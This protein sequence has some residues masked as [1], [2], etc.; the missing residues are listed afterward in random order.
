MFLQKYK[1]LKA[2]LNGNGYIQLNEL[3]EALK[4][5][6][7]DIPGYQARALEEEFKKSDKNHDGKLNLE[8]FEKL[9]A[10][11]KNEKEERTF[12][13]SVKPPSGTKQIVSQ[14]N[15]SI[16][17]T[18]RHSE[19]LAFSKWINQNLAKDPDL[20]LASKPID[21]ETNDLYTRCNDGLVLWYIYIFFN[22]LKLL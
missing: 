17:H 6:G 21:P 9:Y 13:K 11:L 14:Q 20:N 10:K 19:Q 8:E 4:A 18:V 16:V 5:V 1:F 3:R 15:D 12:K 7:I 22:L 2:D